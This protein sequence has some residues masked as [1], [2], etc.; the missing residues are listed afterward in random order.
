MSS[1]SRYRTSGLLDFASCHQTTSGIAQKERSSTKRIAKGRSA[2][3]PAS[4]S[5]NC[6]GV[7]RLSA[8]VAASQ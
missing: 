4:P 8:S 2:S 7:R 1:F 6:I 5:V 3:T